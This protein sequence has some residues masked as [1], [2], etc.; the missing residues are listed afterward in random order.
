MK[1]PIYLHFIFF[2][3]AAVSMTHVDALSRKYVTLISSVHDHYGT[4]SVFVISSKYNKSNQQLKNLTISG[5][6]SIGDE[7]SKH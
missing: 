1:S 6:F 5:Y 4:S 3:C 7:V 2:T